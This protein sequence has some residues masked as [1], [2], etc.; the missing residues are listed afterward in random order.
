MKQTIVLGNIYTVDAKRPFAKAAL[1]EDGVFTCIGDVD[2]VKNLA[3]EDA[4][5]LDYGENFIYPGFLESH[6]HGYLGGYRAVGQADLAGIP[7]ADYSKY[8]EIIKDFIEKNQQKDIYL[9]AGWTENEEYVTKAYLDE[10]CVDKPLIM[11]TAGGH[12]CLLNTK[13]LE[14]AGIDAEYAGKVGYDLVHVDDQGQPDGYICEMPA[15]ELMKRITPTFEE[16][17]SYLLAWQD[18]ILKNGF[19]AVADAGADL[20]F[21]EASKAYHELEEEGKLKLRTYSYLTVPD[22]AEN[23]KAEVARIVADR[24]KYSGEYY[25]IIGVKAFLDGVTEA[26][27][28]WQIEEYADQ[29]GYHGVKRFNDHDKMVELIAAAEKEGLSV[30]VHSEGDGATHFMLSCIED[31]E[32]ITCDKDQRNVLAHLHFV[33]NEDIRR[34]AETA[35]IPAVAPMWTAKV[36]GEYDNEVVYVG[37]ELA[38]SAYPIKSFFDIGTN[39]VYHSDY[40]ISPFMDVKRSFYMAENRAL[41]EKD[42]GGKATQRNIGEAVTREQSLC[43]LTINIAYAWHQEDRM[44]SIEVGKIAN[45]TVFDCDFLND[46]AEKVANANIVATIIDGEEVYKA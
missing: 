23:P 5:V 46:E 44:G 28:A 40:P 8:R 3:R 19:T 6:S 43:A 37:E 14:F 20:F 30:H 21:P 36:P 12:S 35:S 45:M 34:M 26:H 2:E 32:K 13:A 11:N 24:E 29:P 4:Q 33:V 7:V 38:E 1:T 16:A 9:A 17:K 10:I 22:N 42:L 25:H 27:T 39:V 41:P 31:A 18:I 15:L